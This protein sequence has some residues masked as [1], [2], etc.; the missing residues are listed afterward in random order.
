MTAKNR[1]RD[2]AIFK[3]YENNV[4]AKKLSEFYL[5]GTQRIYELIRRGRRA[6][7]HAE[8]PTPNIHPSYA[9]FLN[10][11]NAIKKM[12]IN[13]YTKSNC[14]NCIA[15]K[16][17]LDVRGIPYVE[18]DVELGKRWENLLREFP[19]ARQMPQ[20][21]INDQRVGGLAGLQAALQKISP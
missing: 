1:M 8:N 19:D 4:P 13:L 15:A 20:I 3:D 2:I 21:F 14:P 18:I 7:K 12:H 17:L 9:E 11:Y 10:S 5:I 16:Q 6:K